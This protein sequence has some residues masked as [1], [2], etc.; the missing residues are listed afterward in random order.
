MN[1]LPNRPGH[2]QCS[3][4]GSITAAP[5]GHEKNCVPSA[6]AQ[7]TPPAEPHEDD[8]V[9]EQRLAELEQMEIDD[10]HELERLDVEERKPVEAPVAVEAAVAVEAPVAVE[11]P[12]AVQPPTA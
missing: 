7:L 2:F 12:V 11:P 8:E 10:Q 1:K 6:Q 5:E 4:C 3:E 9:D